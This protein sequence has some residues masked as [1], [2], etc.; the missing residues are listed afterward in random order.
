MSLPLCINMKHVQLEVDITIL[1]KD[2]IYYDL[3]N[4]CSDKAIRVLI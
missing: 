1:F 3:N 2:N 4:S